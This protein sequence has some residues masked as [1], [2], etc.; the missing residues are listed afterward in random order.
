M[1]IKYGDKMKH[2]RTLIDTLAE[3]E[4]KEKAYK[5]LLD[6]HYY[7]KEKRLFYFDLVLK[8]QEEL[9]KVKFQLRINRE[10]K[11]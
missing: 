2:K 11:K 3:L 1:F 4:I 9:K 7:D 6:L 8:T 10:M 5:R